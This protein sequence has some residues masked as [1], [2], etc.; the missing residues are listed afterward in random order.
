LSETVFSVCPLSLLFP[1]L[2]R[3][4][5]M[6]QGTQ[7]VDDFALMCCANRQS[8]LGVLLDHS[9]FL[10]AQLTTSFSRSSLTP[11]MNPV[12]LLSLVLCLKK[13]QSCLVPWLWLN[14]RLEFVVRRLMDVS[15][16]WLQ[17][18]H[19][20]FETPQRATRKANP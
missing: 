19:K 18:P 13:G 4:G 3:A 2:L 9:L 20:V 11:L 14:S 8:I 17:G 5:I 6:F 7:F 15:S 10:L 1:F 16:V 12:T